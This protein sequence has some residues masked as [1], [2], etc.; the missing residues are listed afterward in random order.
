MFLLPLRGGE[1]NGMHVDDSHAT[2]TTSL[3]ES[4]QNTQLVNLPV[5]CPLGGKGE[6]K[7]TAVKVFLLAQTDYESQRPESPITGVG[8]FGS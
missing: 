1:G 5:H 2:F 3:G 4:W 6:K 8:I 7:Q